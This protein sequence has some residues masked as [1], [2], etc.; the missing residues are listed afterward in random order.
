VALSPKDTTDGVWK[1]LRDTAG[2]LVCT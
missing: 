1:A 2:T